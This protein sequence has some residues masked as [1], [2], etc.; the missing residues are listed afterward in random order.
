MRHG[1]AERV[2]GLEIDREFEFGGLLDRQI[3]GPGSFEDLAGQRCGLTITR[4]EA[5][6]V[7]EKATRLGVFRPL[8]DGRQTGARSPGEAL[9]T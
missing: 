6:A 4:R 9:M 8:I 5:G 3:A 1:Q 7:A 2:G